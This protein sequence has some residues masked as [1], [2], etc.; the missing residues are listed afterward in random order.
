MAIDE[1]KPAFD[2]V[3]VVGAGPS[4]LLLSLLLIRAGIDVHLLDAAPTL[5]DQPR[6]AHYG[7]PAIPD[8]RRAGVLDK[9]KSQ[10]LTLNTMCW[11]KL[12]QTYIAGM[13]TSETLSNDP[14]YGDVRTVSLA[15][16]ELDALMLEE[17][18][19]QGGQVSWE[20]R[21]LE[22]QQDESKA[23]VKVQT[24]T[25]NEK[26]IEAD[27]VVGCDG[28]NSIVRKSLFGEEFPGFTWNQKQIVATNTYYDFRKFGYHDANFIIDR[29]HLY[30]A[31]IID[32]KGL[33]RVTYGE[34]P[35]LTREQLLERQPKKFET[36]LPGNPKPGD[37]EMVNFSPYRMHQRVAE[38]FRVGR[39]MLAADAAHLCNPFGG[40]GITG[41]FVD[42]G[43]LYDC[44]YGIWT[45][46][47]DDSILDL[48]S[49]VRRQK[50]KEIIDP[51]STENFKRVFDQ[52]AEVAGEK[53]HFLV[54]CKKAAEDKDFARQM[55]SASFG[56][57]HDFTQYYGKN[58]GR[59]LV[60]NDAKSDFSV[61]HIEEIAPTGAD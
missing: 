4:G 17:F 5:D 40:L 2:K 28:A 15:L 55:H 51:I 1:M 60:N 22:V 18:V 54:L 59:G 19:K 50:Y 57:R 26:I 6:A 61:E 16:Q 52:D 14:E 56:I 25:E 20:H 36:I 24:P 41:G 7:P 58:K 53:D 34:E 11:R 13:D 35:G 46:Q 30:M 33:W 12:D 21:V 44:L 49:E 45:H 9:I 47:A 48:Y 38:K 8:L 31:A 10:G 29:D 27:Y 39:V 43:C 23:W 42:V 3:I 32:D 37:Y